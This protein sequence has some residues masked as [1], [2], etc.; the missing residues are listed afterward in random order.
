[1][2]IGRGVA[3]TSAA[4]VLRTPELATMREAAESISLAADQLRRD[5]RR[6]T[7]HGG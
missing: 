6:L 2:A 3:G 4:E 7:R 5:C 1:M